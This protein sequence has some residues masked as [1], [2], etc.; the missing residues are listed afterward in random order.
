M[1][2]QCVYCQWTLAPGDELCPRCGRWQPPSSADYQSINEPLDDPWEYDGSDPYTAN[3]ADHQGT[4][5]RGQ[6]LEPVSHQRRSLP[7]VTNLTKP[8][9]RQNNLAVK[10]LVIVLAVAIVGLGGGAIAVMAHGGL[11]SPGRQTAGV[12]PAGQTATPS[13][14]AQAT[15]TAI[16]NGETPTP[17][18]TPTPPPSNGAACTSTDG[19]T[20]AYQDAPR[21]YFVYDTLLPDNLPLK[22]LTSQEAPAGDKVVAGNQVTLTLTLKQPSA[23]QTLAVCKVTLEL[24]N[25]SPLPSS[26]ANIWN[27]CD[28][29]YLNPG[30]PQGG[31]CGGGGDNDGTAN[32]SFPT[33]QTGAS[34]TANVTQGNNQP[35]RITS[36]SSGA[37]LVNVLFAAPGIYTFKIGLWSDASGPQF[38]G[39]T[40]NMTVFDGQFGHRWGSN[41]CTTADMQALLPP[42]SNPPGEFI[43][44]GAPST[45]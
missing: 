2:Q 42:P 20:L 41:Q 43:C 17:P 37:I 28:G 3:T 7:P 32:L 21:L 12:V 22:P 18:A 10:I 40:I 45:Q 4:F 31:G 27:V 36:N 23:P 29:V 9:F 39:Q 24:A 6:P 8:T 19:P 15:P 26:S 1:N 11:F 30:G 44:P 25:F 38:N 5:R 14:A 16:S 34:A 35:G 13:P 33:P